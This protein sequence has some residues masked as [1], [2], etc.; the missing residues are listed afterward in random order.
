MVHL[1]IVAP[2]YQSEHALDL[3]DGS[4]GV[5]NLVYLER[6][7]RRPEGDV[8]LCDVAREDASVIV[9]DLRELDIDV[10]GSISIEEIDSQ[11]SAAATAAATAARRHGADPVVWEEVTSHTSESVEL[12]HTFLIYMVLAM[13]IA[14]V[15]IYLDE[16]I[17]IVGAMVVG[18]EFGPIAG[19]C[20]AIVNGHGK[21]VGRSVKAL[22]VGFPL[23]IAATVL[24]TL[25]LRASGQ[26]P[27]TIDFN[28][29]TLTRFIAEPNFFSAYVAVLA[30]VVGI[31]S[32]TSAK[33]S[34]L[35]GV[36]ISVATIPAAAY[37]GVTIAYGDWEIFSKAAIQLAI[38]LTAIFAAG[39]LTLYVQ[40]LVYI[41]RRRAHLSEGGA[42]DRA[43]L[44]RRPEP[45]LTRRQRSEAGRLLADAPVAPSTPP[46][47]PR[48]VELGGS[49]A[50]RPR[51]A[52]RQAR[53][54][55][56]QADRPPPGG[57]GRGALGGDRLPGAAGPPDLRADR[58]RATRR[59]PPTGPSPAST[60]RTPGT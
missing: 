28:S 27:E 37:M 20:V 10:E 56:L 29:H 9:A 34:V 14:S 44:P 26:I 42:R 47:A 1:R 3:L 46:A 19:A 38:N 22:A 12:S 13:L 49:G 55:G 17:L 40:R 51:A 50:R 45:A 16:P 58:P 6:A 15:G 24:A 36:L 32:L 53:P 18:P 7:A 41:R 48:Q 2:S 25:L 39:L 33:S 4:P 52:A 57:A 5:C 21:L 31:L 23:G 43:G 59:T 60:R 8:I 30:G 54:Q 35:V 11:I